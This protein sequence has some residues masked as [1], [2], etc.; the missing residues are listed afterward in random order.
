M[1][2]RTLLKCENDFRIAEE[3]LDLVVKLFSVLVEMHYALRLFSKPKL[4]KFIQKITWNKM[5]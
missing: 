5:T 2:S 3:M 1:D 4:V